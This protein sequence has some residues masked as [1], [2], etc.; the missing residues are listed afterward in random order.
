M[1]RIAL[2]LLMCA[3]WDFDQA[4]RD[5]E[6]RGPCHFDGGATA[7]GH[8][9]GGG[10]A[11]G[12]AGGNAGGGTAGAS[13]AGGGSSFD[14]DAGEGWAGECN[15]FQWCLEL[16][17][18]TVKTVRAMAADR[19][20]VWLAG[21]R[22]LLMSWESVSGSFTHWPGTGL[23]DTLAIA[24]EPRGRVIT[25]QANALCE[26][27][28]GGSS[29]SCTTSSPYQHLAGW[30]APDGGVVFVG[31][32]TSGNAALIRENT[33][34]TWSANLADS[35]FTLS[36]VSGRSWDELWAVG[37]GGTVFERVGPGNW[38]AVAVAPAGV[39]WK[40]TCVDGAGRRWLATGGLLGIWQGDGG[41]ALG[42]PMGLS[43]MGCDP[44]SPVLW[45]GDTSGRVYR[46]TDPASCVE[47]ADLDGGVSALVTLAS[48]A[49]V[50][51]S[52]NSELLYRDGGNTASLRS[53]V[54]GVPY[55]TAREP[56]SGQLVVVGRDGLILS[57]GRGGWEH[58]HSMPGVDFNDLA[59]SAP[60]Q[61]HLAAENGQVFDL[62]FNGGY[63]IG[64]R[65]VLLPDA[66]T[67]PEP[68][69]GV[70]K[71]PWGMLA[72]GGHGGVAQRMADTNW[73]FVREPRPG[74]PTLYSVAP[75]GDDALAVG[76][77]QTLWRLRADGGLQVLRDGG[78]AAY[79]EAFAASR[80]EVFVGG[81]GTV[82]RVFTDG[83]VLDTGFA[84][85][86]VVE[87]IGGTGPGDVWVVEGSN[88]VAHWTGAWSSQT[89]SDDGNLVLRTI[90]VAGNQL[91][92]SG[93]SDAGLAVFQLAR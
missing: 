23:V 67:A 35:G 92:V 60:R 22:G 8:G 40:Q 83:G 34:S 80:D 65:D 1:K 11:G 6:A 14:L 10:T 51:A 30:A 33:G 13:G 91:H 69:K 44:V 87:E 49:V 74:Q 27:A 21:D 3:C 79:R 31:F 84:L 2:A 58:A 73:H 25:A 16:P 18:P 20:T 17:Y 71:V 7:G 26:L 85:V 29:F 56:Q 32:D 89:A 37:N 48:G 43:R 24:A 9:G 28:S 45:Y 70:A 64:P 62:T 41:L 90:D 19:D 52:V 63:T 4:R 72:V 50:A 57:H 81:E 59:F 55:A 93:E 76:E 53:G 61:G 12:H 38:R 78:A 46:C 47:S 15:A 88:F 36:A 68:M 75:F 39:P 54:P 5:C 66:G 82:V 86:G 42:N 77:G